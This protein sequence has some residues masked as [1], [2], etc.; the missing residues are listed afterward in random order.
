MEWI[1][2]L[3][4]RIFDWILGLIRHPNSKRSLHV[5]RYRWGEYGLIQQVA[6]NDETA[7]ATWIYTPKKMG[8][9]PAE[10]RCFYLCLDA[11]PAK[12]RKKN[13][14]C[15]HTLSIWTSSVWL[16]PHS[17]EDGDHVERL[18]CESFD[19]SGK[20]GEADYWGSQVIKNLAIAIVTRGVGRILEAKDLPRAW[21]NEIR[22]AIVEVLGVYRDCI[23]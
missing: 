21:R 5:L 12:E 16:R 23:G 10:Q 20:G 22:F 7:I 11:I 19:M 4:T 1:V 17:I 14:R 8:I 9:P 3:A 2:S 6:R 15:T 13:C 18:Y